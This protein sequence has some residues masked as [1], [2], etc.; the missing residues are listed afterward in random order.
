MQIRTILN[1]NIKTIE[2]Q[3][4]LFVLD[5]RVNLVLIVKIA[6]KWN[7]VIKD[8]AVIKGRD[9]KVKAKAKKL[10]TYIVYRK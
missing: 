7:I 9:G 5:L 8:R 10:E 6:E 1:D 2:F 3:D 4:V